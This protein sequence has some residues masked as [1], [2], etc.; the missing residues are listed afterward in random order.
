MLPSLHD[1]DNTVSCKNPSGQR[2][3]YSYL[4]VIRTAGLLQA[5]RQRVVR[6]A[7]EDRLCLRPRGPAAQKHP[8]VILSEYWQTA[9]MVPFMNAIMETG[10]GGR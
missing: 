6:R 3:L 2:Q 4:D 7:D 5:R 8:H 1:T 10:M 9:L